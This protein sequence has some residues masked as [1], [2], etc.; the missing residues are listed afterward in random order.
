MKMGSI[1]RLFRY[2]GYSELSNWPYH[3]PGDV[4]WKPRAPSCI[5]VRLAPE[6]KTSVQALA[7][8]GHLQAATIEV[9]CRL[10]VKRSW[11]DSGRVE[12]VPLTAGD[13]VGA[14]VRL[15]LTC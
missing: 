5:M 6:M 2:C 14:R 4:E 8:S 15:P 11:F 7:H 1:P 12:E 9:D 10:F 13:I 3:V